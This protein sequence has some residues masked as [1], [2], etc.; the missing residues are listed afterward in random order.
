M[1]TALRVYFYISET[2]SLMKVVSCSRTV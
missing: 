2:P 1:F